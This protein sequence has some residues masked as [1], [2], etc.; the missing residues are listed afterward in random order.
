MSTKHVT[1]ETDLA[2][3]RLVARISH[4]LDDRDFDAF[5][6]LLTP[7]CRFV[8]AGRELQGAPAIRAWLDTTPTPVCHEVTNV[9]VSNGSQPDTVHVVADVVMQ[10]KRDDRW[11]VG[12]VARYHDTLVGHD[13]DWKWSQRL[14]TLR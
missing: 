3:R 11:S 4:L 6:G 8:V 13:R 1:V 9:V 10:I 5:V 2:V 14:I 7:D 12:V